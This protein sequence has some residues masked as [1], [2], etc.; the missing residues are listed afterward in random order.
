MFRARARVSTPAGGGHTRCPRELA[1]GLPAA[2]SH[3]RVASAASAPGVPTLACSTS[4]I[5]NGTRARVNATCSSR[6][7]PKRWYGTSEQGHVR[8]LTTI[9]ARVQ[10]RECDA[11]IESVIPG[12]YRAAQVVGTRAEKE[13]KSVS[14]EN[15]RSSKLYRGAL[16]RARERSRERERES[17]K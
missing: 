11:G 6:V 10:C 9:G 2:T 16:R 13:K 4:M 12:C 8:V 5:R 3:E 7:C 15:K 14:R 1:P 17:D